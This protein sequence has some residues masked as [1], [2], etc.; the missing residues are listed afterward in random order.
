MPPLA[1]GQDMAAALFSIWLAGGLPVPE[2][3]LACRP[4]Q[5]SS[6]RAML[7]LKG[8]S[9]SSPGRSVEHAQAAAS[10]RHGPPRRL[11]LASSFR[12]ANGQSLAYV[13]FE[14]EPGRII[15][16][17]HT[18]SAQASA[19][20]LDINPVLKRY[21]QRCCSPALLRLCQSSQMTLLAPPLSGVSMPNEQMRL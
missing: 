4:R 13:Y 20:S 2:V 8:G 16:L 9:A 6:T 7:P 17:G 3:A 21:A 18:S 15:S 5:R 10:R 14:G 11:T 12:D 1:F 19:S